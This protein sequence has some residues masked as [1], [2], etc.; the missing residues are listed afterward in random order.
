[1]R[2]LMTINVLNV[3]L[4]HGAYDESDIITKIQFWYVSRQKN[5]KYIFVD[6]F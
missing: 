1:M 3:V 4:D 6:S 5:Q 2:K